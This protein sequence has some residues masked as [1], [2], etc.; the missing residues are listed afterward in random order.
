MHM[1]KLKKN[2][3]SPNGE[4]KFNCI[5]VLRPG[6]IRLDVTIARLSGLPL[7]LV[8]NQII[9]YVKMNG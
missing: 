9:N 7:G 8:L 6:F 1:L 2:T 3:F 4:T 5:L